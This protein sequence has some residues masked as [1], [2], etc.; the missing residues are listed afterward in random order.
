MPELCHC[1]CVCMFVSVYVYV[2]LCVSVYMRVL[3]LW[4]VSVYT[5]VHLSVHVLIYAFLWRISV[6]LLCV[7]AYVCVYISA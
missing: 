7:S 1:V 6:H 5:Y 3:S 2:R 4:R